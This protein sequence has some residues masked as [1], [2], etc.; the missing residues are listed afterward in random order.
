MEVDELQVLI[1]VVFERFLS[2]LA[3]QVS[4]SLGF[5]LD[6]SSTKELFLVTTLFECNSRGYDNDVDG[7]HL[8]PQLNQHVLSCLVALK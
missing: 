3:V 8:A 7:D 2:V 1:P 4:S 5:P 6:S